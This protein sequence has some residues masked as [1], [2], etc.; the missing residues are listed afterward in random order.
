MLYS[1]TDSRRSRSRS[2][3]LPDYNRDR[4]APPT[5]E[6]LQELDDLLAEMEGRMP[7]PA[8]PPPAPAPYVLPQQQAP[9]PQALPQQ[10]QQQQPL[11]ATQ[12]VDQVHCSRVASLMATQPMAP[13]SP[14]PREQPTLSC[15]VCLES[16]AKIQADPTRTMCS[17]N[18]GHLFCSS[19]IAQV[20][21]QKK[22]CPMCRKKL[23]KKQ[24][25]PIYI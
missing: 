9:P 4:D 2:P 6:F 10:Q 12:M 18:C 15:M 8:P 23:T 17:T 19:C 16:W 20:V 21:R 3:Q 7:P 24:Y 14:P 25:H 13:P 1:C 11:T 5:P 22:Q